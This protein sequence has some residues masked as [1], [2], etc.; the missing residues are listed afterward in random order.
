MHG[1]I[2]HSPADT[3]ISLYTPNLRYSPYTIQQHNYPHTMHAE[4]LL[5]NTKRTKHEQPKYEIGVWQIA[6]VMI[7]KPMRRPWCRD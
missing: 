7:R 2:L 6:G 4:D 3:L 1:M 5:R